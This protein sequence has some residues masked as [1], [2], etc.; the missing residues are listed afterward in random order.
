MSQFTLRSAGS[1]PDPIAGFL[2]F[3][4]K[5]LRWACQRTPASK[6][7]EIGKDVYSAD[8]EDLGRVHDIK[9]GGKQFAQLRQ[10]FLQQETDD[11]VGTGRA[12]A[13]E[14]HLPDRGLDRTADRPDRQGER[15]GETAV[16]DAADRVAR[17][18]D[19]AQ[20]QTGRTADAI[21]EGDLQ[22]AE[23]VAV[24]QAGGVLGIGADYIAVPLDQLQYD[25]QEERFEIAM[26][27]EQWNQLRDEG[28][29]SGTTR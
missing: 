25:A 18:A 7:Q 3:A 29:L 12:G 28:R 15:R 27:R 20:D 26:T 19:R 14:G 6:D 22:S 17:T 10:S 8:G 11:R 2:C 24:V 21:G 5:R 16:R 4:R 23:I 13:R 9:L 1:L